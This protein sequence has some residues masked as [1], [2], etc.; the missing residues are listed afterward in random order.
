MIAWIRRQF[1]DTKTSF[2]TAMAIVGGLGVLCC[3]AV[4]AIVLLVR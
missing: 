4:I 3:A 1:R 2:A